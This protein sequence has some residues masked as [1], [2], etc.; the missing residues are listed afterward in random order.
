[1]KH[2]GKNMVVFALLLLLVTPAI[3]GGGA[4]ERPVTVRDDMVIALGSDPEHLNPAITTGY[5]VAAVTADVYSALVWR[6]N[7]GTPQP[8]LARSW[9]VS[10]GDTVFTFHLHDNVQWHDGEPF[11]SADVKFSMDEVLSQY[12]GR[13]ERIYGRIASI[14]TPNDS[15]VV[16]TLNEPYAPFLISLTVFDAPILP[17]HIFEGQNVFD[18]AATTAPVGTG[19]Y[20]FVNWD[21]GNQIVLERNENYFGDAA[22]ISRVIFQMI[23]DENARTV[24]LQTG[25]VDYIWGFYLPSAGLAE[26]RADPNVEVWQGVR[27][28]ALHFLFVNNDS[29]PLDNPLVRQAIMHAIDRDLIVDL[30]MEGLGNTAIGPMGAAFPYLYDE[31][32]DLSNLY[33]YDLERARALLDE[34]GVGEFELTIVYDS[35]RPAFADAVDIMRDGLSNIGVRLNLQPQERSVMI[36]SVYMQ[37]NYDLSM[38]SFTSG[39]DPSIGYHRIYITQAFGTP[40]V[41]ATGYSNPEVDELLAEAAITVD[42]GRRGELYRQANA[43]LAEDLPLFP[44]FEE[45]SVEANNR[46]LTGLRESLDVRDKIGRARWAD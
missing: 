35:G 7:E 31:S 18:H 30:A 25:E 14:E 28:P 6:D 45:M 29:E 43:I 21:R 42:L 19:P 11:T 24:A 26:L 8:D 37:R 22:N 33:P 41:S 10:A 20:R 4:T 34:A 3:F 12:H 17:K 39:G 16:I 32:F 46:E 27:I 9:D 5:P 36:E 40:F 15:T 13:F 2:A 38:Q 44:L 23:P 1:M